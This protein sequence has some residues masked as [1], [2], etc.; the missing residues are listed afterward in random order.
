MQ[1]LL[2]D[3]YILQQITEHIQNGYTSGQV[4]D[5]GKW[6]EETQDYDE[7]KDYWWKFDSKGNIIIN[8]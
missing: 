6:N 1:Y 3:G 8:D 2:Q 7:N 4:F 5:G